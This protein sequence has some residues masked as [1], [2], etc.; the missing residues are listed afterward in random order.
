MCRFLSLDFEYSI[1]CPVDKTNHS[2]R[3]QAFPQ[4]RGHALDAVACDGAP[5]VE[6][7]SCNKACRSL[8]ESSHY[9][10]RMYPESVGYTQ[11]Q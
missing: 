9:W 4:L 11:S 5:L 6:R 7:P 10:Q 2:V 3:F 8:L 1:K